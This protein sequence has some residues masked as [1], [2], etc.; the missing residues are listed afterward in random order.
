MSFFPDNFLFQFWWRP[1]DFLDLLNLQNLLNLL[2]LLNLSQKSSISNCSGFQSLQI[3][4]VGAKSTG[5]MLK[6]SLNNSKN[7][8]L[9][10]GQ[11]WAV[12][13]E[14]KE[15]NK[16][17]TFRTFSW[18]EIFNRELI[19]AVCVRRRGFPSP[20]MHRCEDWAPCLPWSIRTILMSLE[21]DRF[22]TPLMS[23]S[24][25]SFLMLP[26]CS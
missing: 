21:W 19:A 1:L 24:S 6:V 25:R 17:F 8:V 12:G 2:N 11:L 20:K 4:I 15:D 9:A 18:P 14:Q 16:M 7:R 22:A 10:S 5:N 13:S 3:S 26:Y 23:T